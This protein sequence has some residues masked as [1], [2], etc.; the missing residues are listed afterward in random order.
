[1]TIMVPARMRAYV[2]LANL[3]RSGEESRNVRDGI[4][5]PRWP[6]MSASGRASERPVA[7]FLTAA[8]AQHDVSW[9]FCAAA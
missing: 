6:G 5:C 8:V 1:V 3:S 2:G 7:S 4:K 9:R